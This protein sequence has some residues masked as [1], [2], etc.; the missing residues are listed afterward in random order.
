MTEDLS[1][2]LPCELKLNPHSSLL[3][4]FHN[5]CKCWCNPTAP[6]EQTVSPHVTILS[7]LTPRVQL[8]W[9]LHM[10]LFFYSN[11]EPNWGIRQQKWRPKSNEHIYEWKKSIKSSRV[12]GISRPSSQ[13]IAIW[14]ADNLSPHFLSWISLGSSNLKL[15]P[16][17]HNTKHT[18]HYTQ[19]TTHNTQHTQQTH[20]LLSFRSFDYLEFKANSSNTLSLKKLAK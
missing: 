10:L 12:K 6:A 9:L 11:W 15:L 16:T 3:H 5:G 4:T 20:L 13:I 14:I 19:H 1:P 8:V 17:T 2:L 18:T 7:T